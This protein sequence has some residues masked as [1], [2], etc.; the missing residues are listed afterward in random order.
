MDMNTLWTLTWTH[1]LTRMTT[2]S[3]TITARPEHRHEYGEEDSW[4]TTRRGTLTKPRT[5]PQTLT[6]NTPTDME[7][8]MEMNSYTGMAIDTTR[9]KETDTDTYT[10]CQEQ[11]HDHWPRILTLSVNSI[12]GA[13]GTT[14]LG[15][16]VVMSKLLLLLIF[17]EIYRFQGG[18]PPPTWN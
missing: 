6:T 10:D 16:N 13:L 8:D 3:D 14:Y 1:S 11:N 9:G 18:F 17:W 7:T 15:G 2:D 5:R 12:L 4:T